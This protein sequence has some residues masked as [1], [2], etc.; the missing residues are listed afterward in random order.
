MATPRRVWKRQ[1]EP[2][3]GTRL[4]EI[5]DRLHEG[6]PTDLSG[7][8]NLSQYIEQLRERYGLALRKS[9]NG[10]ILDGRA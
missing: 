4:R 6:G 1:T 3:P 8:A 7:T 2:K 5:W 10:W 9:P